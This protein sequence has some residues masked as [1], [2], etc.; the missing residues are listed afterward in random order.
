M[1]ATVCSEPL[2][3]KH[4]DTHDI[5]WRIGGDGPVDLTG[6]SIRL[7]AQPPVGPVIEL[8]ATGS[9]DVITHTLTG[10]LPVG[11]YTIEV[12]TTQAGLV[13]TAPSDGYGEL[14]VL[15]DLG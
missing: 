2:K 15:P 11:R 13:R 5:S 10:D 1:A 14:V 9:G 12:E 8:S 3:V 6:V 4:G 7:L